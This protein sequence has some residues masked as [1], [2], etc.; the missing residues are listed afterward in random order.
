MSRREQANI[1]SSTTTGNEQA[2]ADQAARLGALNEYE[3]RYPGLRY[4]YASP[5]LFLFDFCLFFIICLGADGFVGR[6]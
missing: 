5:F 3:E 1:N 6:G 4:V 2:A